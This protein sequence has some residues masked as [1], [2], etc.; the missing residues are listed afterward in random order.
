VFERLHIQFLLIG[1]DSNSSNL[2]QFTTLHS[3][4]P[5]TLLA[6]DCE[7]LMLWEW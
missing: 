1:M 6:N 2:S 4:P 7:D 5:L 3:A